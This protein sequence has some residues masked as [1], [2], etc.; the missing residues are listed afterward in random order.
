M[1]LVTRFWLLVSGFAMR[2]APCALQVQS[3]TFRLWPCLFPLAR[4]NYSG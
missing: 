2:P 3:L 4:V 1:V